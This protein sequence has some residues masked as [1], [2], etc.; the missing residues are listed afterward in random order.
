MGLNKKNNLA[1]RNNCVIK[2]Y[3]ADSKIYSCKSYYYLSNLWCDG[4][5]F[6]GSSTFFLKRKE[7]IQDAAKIIFLT[8]G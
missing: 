3:N 7:H 6:T 5:T 2:F 1:S 8:K 4:F